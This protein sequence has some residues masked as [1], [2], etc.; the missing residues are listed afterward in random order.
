MGLGLVERLLQHNHRVIA[1][2]LNEQ[3][4]NNAAKKGAI[5]VDSLAELVKKLESPRDIWIMAPPGE[6][7]EKIINSLSYLLESQDCLI[8]GGNSYYKDSIRRAAQ[9]KEK[10]ISFLDIGTSG[11]ILG[12]E[13]GFCLMVGGEKSDFQ[14]LEPVFKALCSN[15][16]YAYIGKSG[17]GHFVKMAHNG[18][19]YALLE[20][21]AEGF[22]IIRAKKEFNFDLAQISHLWNNG[23]IIRSRLLELS[24][25]IFETNP[26]FDSISGYIEETGEGRWIVKEAI[27]EDVP[28]PIITLSLLKRLRSHQKDSFSA[29]LIALLRNKF[30]GHKLH[31]Y[32]I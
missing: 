10:H 2:D 4:R 29:K 22:E 27:D 24:A 17:S 9:L 5:I 21:Y 6:T 18:I 30:G 15:K 1:Y 14:R 11:G 13:S 7:T 32:S 31:Y 28:A 19:E 3:A 20:S 8:D 23:S 16:G 26:Q 25:Q 12:L